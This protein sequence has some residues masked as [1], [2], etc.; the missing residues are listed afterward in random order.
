MKKLLMLLIL[1]IFVGNA[2]G[3]VVEDYSVYPETLFPGD[4]GT[5]TVTISGHD[6]MRGVTLFGNGLKILSPSY[7]KI[8]V[9]DG[10][11]SLNFVTKANKDGIYYPK[12]HIYANGTSITYPLIVKVESLQPEILIEDSRIF[13]NEVNRINFTLYNPR[14]GEITSVVVIPVIQGKVY[15]KSVYFR[16]IKGNS[17][18]NGDFYLYTLNSSNLEFTIKYKNGNNAKQVKYVLPLDVYESRGTRIEILNIPHHIF[19]HDVVTIEGNITNLRHDKIH[20][21]SIKAFGESMK[22]TSAYFPTIGS[23]ETKQFQIKLSPHKSGMKKVELGYS[24]KDQFEK[25]YKESIE[26][27]LVVENESV[28]R[29]TEIEVDENA[30]KIVLSGEICNLGS[31]KVGSVTVTTH[32]EP[33]SYFIGDLEAADFSNFDLT[34]KNSSSINL[35][36]QFVNEMGELFTINKEI[37]IPRKNAEHSEVGMYPVLIAAGIIVSIAVVISWKKR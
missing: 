1:L 4:I 24:Y 32:S 7:G 16:E 27:E 18:V 10:K 17:K 36:V 15:P 8:G 11:I 12:L 21:F 37:S 34:L 3:L 28:I 25:E 30:G 5:I 35:S 14:E 19:M 33:K 26:A 23:G 13:R 2:K 31:A 9:P 22:A 20:D 29:I 6:E